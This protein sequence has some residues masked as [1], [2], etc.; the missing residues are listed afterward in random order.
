MILVSMIDKNP[1]L[2]DYSYS[3]FTYGRKGLEESEIYGW[4][5]LVLEAEEISQDK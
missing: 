5:D 2:N 4:D 1:I 3:I